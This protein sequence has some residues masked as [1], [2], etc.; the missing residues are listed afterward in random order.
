VRNEGPSTH[1]F[2]VVRTDL[3]PSS[4]PQE[5][6]VVSEETPGVEV[7]DEIEDIEAGQNKQLSVDLAAGDY[8]LLCNVSGH[9]QLGMFTEFTVR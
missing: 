4:L 5:N 7:V 1:E 8:V 6:G 3:N 9:Y 2:V